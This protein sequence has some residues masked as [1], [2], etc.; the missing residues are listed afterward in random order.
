MSGIE[1]DYDGGQLTLESAIK[2]LDD[3]GIRAIGYTTPSHTPARP[4]W[5]V[6]L[7]FETPQL[8]EKRASFVG[9]VDDILGGGV[10]DKC[11]YS[12]AQ[13]FYMGRVVGANYRVMKSDGVPLD[14]IH[15]PALV[16]A[17]GNHSTVQLTVGED[18]QIDLCSALSYWDADNR[19][20]WVAAGHALYTIGDAGFR[21]WA[22]W[23]M[24][25]PKWRDGDGSK[26]LSFAGTRSHYREIFKQAAA[27][28]WINPRGGK[29]GR[30]DVFDEIGDSVIAQFNSRYCRVILAGKLRVR[31][32]ITN[33]YLKSEDFIKFYDNKK[34][35]IAPREFINPAKHWFNHPAAV[36]YRDGVVF[37]PGGNHTPEQFNLW[38]GFAVEPADDPNA[39]PLVKYH[40]EHVICADN[41]VL[42]RF[43]YNWVARGIQ[44]PGEP[45]G[46]AIIMRG[47]EGTGK[48]LFA[49]FLRDLWGKHGF[50]A[51][52]SKSIIGN[53]NGHLE[54][55]AFLFA[56]EASFT[57]DKK[58]LGT[59]KS[60]I[61]DKR[62]VIEQKGL[63]A[64]EIDNCIKI[65]MASN[66]DFIIP[67]SV[68]NRRFAVI[69]I[70]SEYKGDVEY[71][72]ELRNAMTSDDVRA[73]FLRFMLDFP[74][75][76]LKIPDTEAMLDQIRHS[77]DRS[78]NTINQWLS[79]VLHDGDPT[80][81]IDW[82]G[83]NPTRE[84]YV[85]YQSWCE[86]NRR[87]MYVINSFSQRLGLAFE[88]KRTMHSKGFVFYGLDDVR[89]KALL[90]FNII[91]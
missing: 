46:T 71:F 56:D 87:R 42:I 34:I 66:D 30:A 73:S 19:D 61:T 41:P 40:I 28:G 88:H 26:W 72:Q 91:I 3:A 2:R 57:L 80:S 24:K 89:K 58:S 50:T 83:F 39:W 68:G 64:Y 12:L 4:K 77:E 16:A 54:K 45:V 63:G 49:N 90:R 9:F 70:S 43:I 18:V 8:P 11:S 33:E 17:G 25:S 29:T 67:T 27:R 5:R 82:N 65:I 84:L 81:G 23:S 85:I 53:F 74:V 78:D 10:L 52:N 22:E 55:C 48:G 75:S 21:I 44:R 76:E 79:D 6:L 14:R 20:E 62:M 59:L 86:S 47:A 37:K 13:A 69:D 31:D 1:C 36:S 32:N 38:A 15:A 7:P 60:M 51:N 35:E